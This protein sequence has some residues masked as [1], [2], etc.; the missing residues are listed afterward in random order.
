MSIPYTRHPVYLITCHMQGRHQIAPDAD[1]PTCQENDRATLAAE[2][3][4]RADRMASIGDHDP[5]KQFAYEH[6]F[7]DE[8]RF[9]K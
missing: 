4:R 5:V 7:S 8:E 9:D 2:D 6:G 1:C 3:I